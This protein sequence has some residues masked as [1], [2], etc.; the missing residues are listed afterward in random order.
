MN[1][2]QLRPITIPHSVSFEVFLP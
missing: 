1:C 2:A